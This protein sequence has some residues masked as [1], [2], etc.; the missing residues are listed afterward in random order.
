MQSNSLPDA[1]PNLPE[2]KTKSPSCPTGGVHMYGLGFKSH[3]GYVLFPPV[4][5]GGR[6]GPCLGCEQQRD[7][8]VSSKQIRG[9][10]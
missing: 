8:L 3:L 6:R 5:F 1:D 7:Y 4:T 9:Q 2:M 10:I